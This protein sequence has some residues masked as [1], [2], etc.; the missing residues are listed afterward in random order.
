MTQSAVF[1][2]TQADAVKARAGIT[3]PDGRSYV[4]YRYDD[5]G[6]IV[7]HVRMAMATGR[8]LL[9]SGPP[10]SGK[11]SLARDVALCLGRRYYEKVVTSRVQARDL[12]W[13]WD[14]VA[15][16]ADVQG[17]KAWAD[18]P[19]RFVEPE[20]L[21]WAFASESARR[22]GASKDA[23]KLPPAPR[24]PYWRFR[25]EGVEIAEAKGTVI[26]IDEIDKADPDVPNDLLLA[27]GERRFVV[28]ETGDEIESEG[29]VESL[30]FIATNGERDL[31]QAFLRRCIPL[32][33]ELPRGTAMQKIL[34]QHVPG[35]GSDVVKDLVARHEAMVTA[36]DK[37]KTRPPGTAELIDAVRAAAKILASV[38]P[39]KQLESLEKILR[40]TLW[41]RSEP[42]PSVPATSGAAAS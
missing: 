30:V 39:E 35:A 29:E 18:L 42:M 13:R 22:R 32:T 21:W 24:N 25:R 36:A 7:L 16:L 6:D 1:D 8:P 38:E 2:P 34:A 12:Q 3:Q 20:V 19:C 17:P 41:K 14:A 37:D 28:E 5:A 11:S 10:G 4:P 31:P 33:L 27:L 40:S 23:T 9:L 15:R 26:L